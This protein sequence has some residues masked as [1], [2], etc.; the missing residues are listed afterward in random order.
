MAQTKV[1]WQA[2]DEQAFARSR[3]EDKPVLLGISAVW[4]HWCHVMDR[5]TY[6]NDAVVSYINEHYIPVRVDNDER[7]DINERYN[8]GGWPTTAFLTPEGEILAG[9]TYVPPDEMLRMLQQIDH[10]YHANRE[11]ISQRVAEMIYQQEQHGEAQGNGTTTDLSGEIVSGVLTDI[12]A[13]FDSR[14]GGWASPGNPTKFP[15][16][17]TLDLVIAQRYR[18]GESFWAEV[19]NKTLD[20]MAN[21]GMYDQVAGGFFRYSTDRQWQLP[22]FEKMLEAHAGLVRNYVSAA[23]VLDAPRFADVARS[24][25]GYLLSTLSDTEQGGFYG[26]QD[27]DEEYYALNAAGRKG[28]AAPFVDTRIYTNWNADM[29]DTAL[30]AAAALDN[31]VLAEHALRTIE[32]LLAELR[33]S[34]GAMRHNLDFNGNPQ[35]E[36]M[37]TDQAS[38]GHALLAAYSYSGDRAYLDAATTLADWLQ[39][40]LYDTE[41]GGFYD[42]NAAQS[43]TLGRLRY[44]VKSLTENAHAADFLL[45]LYHLSGEQSYRDMALATLRA[46]TEEYRNYGYFASGYAL[47]VEHASSEPTHIII[48]GDP[49]AADTQALAVA[50]IGTYQPWK[51]VQILDPAAEADASLIEQRGYPSSAAATAYVCIGQTCSAPISD[52][53]SL[54]QGLRF[55]V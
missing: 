45:W 43:E 44:P 4:C 11:A 46:F 19:L 38:M 9:A 5:Q 30:Y 34:D 8:Q 2:W 14:Y 7:P 18:S 53:A 40:N 55:E 50:A 24:A 25:I 1:Q 36:G 47:V 10:Y 16:P 13:R 49:N 31:P 29:V 52:V 51:L 23:Q 3:D 37:L 15:H 27:A 33:A 39:A 48:V 32:R 41:Q 35:G 6:S 20:G 22:H 42:R 28:M 17:S 54:R 26:S 21:Y 12:E